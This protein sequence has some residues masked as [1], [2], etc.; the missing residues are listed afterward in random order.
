MVLLY[1]LSLE[2]WFFYIPSPLRERARV[3]GILEFMDRL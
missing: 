2:R 1:P 3:R